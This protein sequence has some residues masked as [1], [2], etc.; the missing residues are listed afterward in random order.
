MPLWVVTKTDDTFDGVCDEDCS[1]REA[2]AQAGPGIGVDIP[3]GKYTIGTQITIDKEFILTGAGAEN[4][5]IQAHAFPGEAASRLF[6]ITSGDV[7]ISAETLQNGK[8][9]T[10]GRS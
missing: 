2:V 8:A 6:E 9:S 7:A 1:L 5:I 4:T 10:G 3:A